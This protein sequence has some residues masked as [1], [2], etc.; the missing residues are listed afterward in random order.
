MQTDPWPKGQ[1]AQKLT[2]S[3]GMGHGPA[4]GGKAIPEAPGKV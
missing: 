4:P 3:L 2:E 1:C